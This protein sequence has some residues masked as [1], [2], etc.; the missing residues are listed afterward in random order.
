MS[1]KNNSSPR[2][3]DLEEEEVN[4]S[5]GKL[6]G[7]RDMSNMNEKYEFNFFVKSI[8]KGLQDTY[9]NII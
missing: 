2:N 6:Q 5:E 7:G 1:P 4:S 3:K 8:L 9:D